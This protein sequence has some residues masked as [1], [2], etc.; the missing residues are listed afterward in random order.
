MRYDTR[1]YGKLEFTRRLG[2]YE[3]FE[4][5][6]VL[7]A[8]R[9][10]DE[11]AAVERFVKAQAY[12]ERAERGG[13]AVVFDPVDGASL[14]AQMRGFIT[15]E[16]LLSHNAGALRISEDG[17]GL[18][19]YSEKSYQMVQAVNFI[20]ANGR[21]RIADFGLKGSLFADTEFEPYH[22]LLKIDTDGCAR[23]YPCRMTALLRHDPRAYL[24]HLRLNWQRPSVW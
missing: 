11:D 5:N 1:F 15:S 24:K 20:I 16:Q 3:L 19:Y 6:K 2:I 7:L 14:R 23:Q 18:K 8:G 21:E 9:Y 10:D 4:L 22:W 13:G 17:C 12:K